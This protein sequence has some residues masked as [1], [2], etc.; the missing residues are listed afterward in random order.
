VSGTVPTNI[1]SFTYSVIASNS[2]GNPATAGPFTVSVTPV[3]SLTFSGSLTY[4]N[5]GV[6][7]SGSLKVEPSTGTISSVTGTR[8]IPGLRG[9]SATI[10][11]DIV[12]VFG[13]Y[14]GAVRVSDPGAH[15]NTTT[16]VLSITLTRTPTG[17]LTGTASGLMG[18]RPCSVSFTV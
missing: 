18:L 15:L 17:Q 7:T 13:L 6:V 12:R 8:T 14:I 4:T 11:M 10:T 9:G 2:V 1:S 16:I 3:V 5:T